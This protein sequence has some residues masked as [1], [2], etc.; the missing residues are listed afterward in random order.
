M[1]YIT[2]ENLAQKI[3]D[4]SGIFDYSD[5]PE[6]LYLPEQKTS[7]FFS[8]KSKFWEKIESMRR[9]TDTS[10]QSFKKKRDYEGSTGWEYEMIMGFFHSKF[11]YSDISSSKNYEQVTSSHSFKIED[12]FNFQSQECID[13]ILIDDRI[14]DEI[15][16]PNTQALINRKDLIQ[17]GKYRPIWVLNF[18]THPLILYPKFNKEIYTFFSPTDLNSFFSSNMMMTG[19]VTNKL[20]VLCKT[21][22]SSNPTPPELSDIT[23]AELYEPENLASKAA[24]LMR[25]HN[26]VVYLADFGG[27]LKRLN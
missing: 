6:I 14:V 17:S 1:A 9:H 24:E 18:H 19:L 4:S 22:S 26:I 5:W 21:R 23:K 15:N 20:W 8:S 2:F 27:N 25:N 13:K 3:A 16:W 7:G 10:V 12:H 11:Y